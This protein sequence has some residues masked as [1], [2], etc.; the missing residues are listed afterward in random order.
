MDR[1]GGLGFMKAGKSTI[2]LEFGLSSPENGICRLP[3]TSAH[4]ES[5]V[6]VSVRI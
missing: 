6:Q 3:R 1:V 5:D 2:I 4:G